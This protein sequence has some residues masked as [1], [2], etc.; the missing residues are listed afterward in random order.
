MGNSRFFF[1]KWINSFFLLKLIFKIFLL[2]ILVRNSLQ[3]VI[4]GGLDEAVLHLLLTQHIKN[5]RLHKSLLWK[6]GLEMNSL[7][8]LITSPCL[9][10][11]SMRA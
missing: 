11:E 6:M 7:H 1:L 10:A 9:K 3:T 4:A 2:A 5:V 8:D